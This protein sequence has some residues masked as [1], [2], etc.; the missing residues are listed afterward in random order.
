MNAKS[1]V[2]AVGRV[3]SLLGAMSHAGCSQK[4]PR[5]PEILLRTEAELARSVPDAQGRSSR[6][7][8]VEKTPSL[9]AYLVELDGLSSLERR[10][11]K[12]RLFVLSGRVRLRAGGEERVLGAGGY[13]AIPPRMAYRLLREG[14]Q[15]LRYMALLTPDSMERTVLEGMGPFP[16]PARSP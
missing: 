1:R 9:G 12:L 14:R 13:A 10:F 5:P 3:L 4:V 16:R 2:L 6:T 11:G 8:Y 15:R 7:W